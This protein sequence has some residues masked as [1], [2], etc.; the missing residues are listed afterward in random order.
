[1]LTGKKVLVLGLAKSGRAAIG[2][3]QATNATI[4]VNVFDKK[5]SIEE[6]DDYVNQGIEMITGGHPEELFERDFDF[7][8][9][10]PGINY[11]KPFILRLKERNIPVYTEIEL[12]FQCAK[13]Q[14][15]VAITGTN[16][17]TTTVH[18]IEEI[19]KSTN[20]KVHLAGNVGY[21]FCD[22]IM[23]HN[24]LQVE[25]HTIILEMS[26]FQ[27]LDIE[28]FAPNVSSII[29]LT[30]DHLDYMLSLEE[31]YASKTNIYKHQTTGT[32]LL[33]IDDLVVLEYI[34]QYPIPCSTITFSLEQD[35]DCCL[36]DN[37]I[38]YQGTKIIDLK[39]I[40]VVGKHNVQN[41]MIATCVAKQLGYDNH[42]IANAIA[43][44][45]GVEH[46]IEYVMNK[47]GKEIYNDSKATNCDATI[48]ALKAF[49]KP[50]V[51]LM[52]GFDKG[53]DLTE[54]KSYRDKVDT[55]IAF[56]AA[57]QR[58]YEEMGIE[59]S[60][61]CENLLEATKKAL[62]VSKEE[63]IILLSPSTSSF[64]EFSGYDQRGKMFKQYIREL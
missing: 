50:V 36:K 47:D 56:G 4:T 25:G 55:F 7:V 54:L 9:K 8:V 41:C 23:E 45:H 11:Q 29:N 62:E 52:G 53:L 61:L 14:N 5:E 22:I 2:L 64:D 1:M 10:N 37:S 13:E 44:F 63:D 40:R 58:F 31:Y 21:P 12:G 30:P 38:Y 18:L 35:A 59:K 46:R 33:N 43:S 57:G 60:Y 28:T 32:F 42:V 34:K 16:G 27:L 48:I 15:Y 3:L 20:D 26:N 24:L 49:D 19:L 6:Y 51:L 39:D 17:K